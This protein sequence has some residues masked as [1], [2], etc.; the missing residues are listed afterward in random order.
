MSADAGK[1]LKSA[2]YEVF[3]G[4]LSVLSIANIFLLLL[5]HD[6]VVD[7]VV[8]IMDAILSLIFLSDFAF[9]L[10]TA[11]SKPKYF[12]RQFGWADLAASI[13]LP[14]VKILR[15]FRVFRAARLLR[16]RGP[17]EMVHD[18]VDNRAQSAL[19]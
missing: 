14:E 2:T 16:E 18:F 1:E 6:D 15:L 7:S 13:P 3:I 10:L 12:L 9:R 8:V 17:D 5:V 4:A 19:L 11:E